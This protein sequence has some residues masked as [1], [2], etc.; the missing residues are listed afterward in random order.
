MDA[1]YPNRVRYLSQDGTTPIDPTA[2][3][4]TGTQTSYIVNTAFIVDPHTELVLTPPAVQI[5]MSG[6]NPQLSWNAVYGTYLYVIYGSDD[7]YDWSEATEVTTSNLIYTITSA[8]A[9]KFYKVAARTYN[10]EE[11]TIG[12][13]LNPASAIGFDNSAVRALPLIPEKGDKK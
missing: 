13:V 5:A 7:P 10:H 11:R 4:S 2:P 1:N 6:T 8:P 12:Q 3:A 9:K